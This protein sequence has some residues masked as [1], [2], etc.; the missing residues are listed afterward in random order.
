MGLAKGYLIFYN[1]CQCLGWAG[2][3]YRLLPYMANQAKATAPG[4][5]P[6]RNPVAMYAD[7]GDHVRLVQTL[8]VLEV[9]HAALGLVRSNPM[10]NAVQ[11]AR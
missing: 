7:L 5:V 1:V 8:A 6:A 2:L 9:L 11:V 4:I 10:I 3:L